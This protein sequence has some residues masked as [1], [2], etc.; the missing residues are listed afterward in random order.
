MPHE[1]AP[2]NV[3]KPGVPVW[4]RN[5]LFLTVGIALVIASVLFQAKNHLSLQTITL[6]LGLVTIAVVL[7]ELLW[8]LCGGT[9]VENQVSSLSNQIER[10]SKAVDVIENSKRIGLEAVYD[11]LGNYGNQ[12]DWIG[13]INTAVDSVDLM[14]R[15]MFGWTHSGELKD[16]VLTKIQRDGVSFRWLVMH[17]SNKYLPLLTEE[18]KNIGAILSAKL[19]IVYKALGEI[20]DALPNDMKSRFQVRLFTHVPLYCSI[21]RVDDKHYVTQYLFSAS[22]DNSPL[23]CVKGGAAWPKCFSQEFNTIWEMSQDFFTEMP[24]LT[25]HST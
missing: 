19:D 16:V 25:T 5:A 17:K 22:S 9:P 20:H 2:S 7:V 4:T 14:G 11:M 23:F 12:S 24:R 21:F 3:T 15:T 13:L 6:N 10:L 18:D 8:K 1:T